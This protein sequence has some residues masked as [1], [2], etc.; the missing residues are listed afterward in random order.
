MPPL[1]LVPGLALILALLATCAA[2]AP[3]PTGVGTARPSGAAPG[4]AQTVLTPPPAFGLTLGLDKFTYAVPAAQNSIT[5]IHATLIFFNH[6][7]TP[8][9]IAVG[10]QLYEWQILD[11]QGQVVWDYAKGRVFPHYLRLV[12]LRQSQLLYAFDVPLQVQSGAPLAPGVY[13]LRGSLPRGL[14]ASASVGFT[15]PR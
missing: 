10:G 3:L 11:A 14:N 5:H 12:T 2:A 7:N 4:H 9:Q 13:T 1:P 6:S 15:V 8:L